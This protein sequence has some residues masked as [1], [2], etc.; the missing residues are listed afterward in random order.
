[1]GA[2]LSVW[3]PAAAVVS[4][5]RDR[6]G[7]R[8]TFWRAPVYRPSLAGERRTMLLADSVFQSPATELG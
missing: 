5:R 4:E 1:M 6:G 7:S 8:A 3:L 2:L